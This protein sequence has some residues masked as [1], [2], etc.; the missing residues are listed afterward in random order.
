LKPL[1][2]PSSFRSAASLRITSTAASAVRF[3]SRHLVSEV[4]VLAADLIRFRL[5]PGQQLLNRPSW[6]VVKSGWKAPPGRMDARL[7]QL[8][9][10]TAGGEFWLD[11]RTGRWQVRDAAGLDIFTALPRACGFAGAS[12]RFALELVERESLLGL[13]ETTGPLNKRGLIREL[14]NIDVLGHASGIH[15]GLRSLYVSIPFLISLRDG[16]AAGIFWDNP[17]RQVWD[18][19]A[20]RSDRLAVTADRGE[21]DLYLLLGPTLPDVMG[22][23]TDLTG[24]MPLPPRWALGYHQCRYSYESRRRLEQIAREFRRRR[25]PCDALYLDLHH[26][27]GHRVFTFGRRF[28]R[29]AAMLRRLARQGFRVVTI[30]DPGVKDEPRFGVLRRGRALDAFVKS[31]AGSEDFIGETWP[32]R[33]RFPDFLSARVRAW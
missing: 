29:P 30:V 28:P 7:K 19:G 12:P 1:R 20:T 25:L 4:A 27:D 24:R 16:R 15:S 22:R 11:L 31:P 6:A 23:Y 26:L 3:Q 17:A 5:A 8:R 13:G 18:L 32:G 9:L 14:W 10:A 21:L 33:A 2:V